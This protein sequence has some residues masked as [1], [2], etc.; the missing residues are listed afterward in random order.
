MSCSKSSSLRQSAE[1]I[2]ARVTGNAVFFH[3]PGPWAVL[4]RL[5][6]GEN[7]D[8]CKGLDGEDSI[9]LDFAVSVSAREPGRSGRG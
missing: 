7:R 4:S 3:G 5:Q 6:A 8:E 9:Q 2:Q 1:R